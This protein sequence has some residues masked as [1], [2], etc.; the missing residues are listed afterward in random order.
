MR[1]MD[2]D[3]AKEVFP[4]GKHVNYYPVWGDENHIECEIRSEPW[5]LGHGTIV[6]KVTGLAGGVSIS[7]LEHRGLGK[8]WE[9]P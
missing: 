9:I 7:H 3:R 6:V 5:A 1:E 4:I 8:R 2:V